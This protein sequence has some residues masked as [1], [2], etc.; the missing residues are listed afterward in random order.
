MTP[1]QREAIER[2]VRQCMRASD[3]WRGDSHP[4]D[5]DVFESIIT[6]ELSP[7][8]ERL[9]GRV[10]E[11]R[12]TLSRLHDEADFAYQ[13]LE[14]SR[15]ESKSHHAKLHA[16]LGA[17]VDEAWALLRATRAAAALSP[18]DGTTQ[19]KENDVSETKEATY[20]SLLQRMVHMTEQ[21]DFDEDLMKEVY[22]AL[23]PP[24]KFEAANEIATPTSSVPADEGWGTESVAGILLRLQDGFASHKFLR[25]SPHP[26]RY[27]EVVEFLDAVEG[28]PWSMAA[29]CC[30]GKAS[31]YVQSVNIDNGT[32]FA[33]DTL[34]AACRAALDSRKEL[35]DG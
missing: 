5:E 19:D 32:W 29:G 22:G 3:D 35:S 30:E 31:Y 33:R 34:A 20:K 7:L 17:A 1:D 6:A 11:L 28:G 2:A 15:A 9:E 24:R 12:R 4:P 25:R 23:L 18:A 16:N 13:Y 8:F 26:P 14:D 10:R 27:P 21:R